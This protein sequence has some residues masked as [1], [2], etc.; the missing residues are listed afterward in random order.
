MGRDKALL[1]VDGVAMA[2]SVASALTDAGAVEVRCIGGDLAGL[3]LLGLDAVP[4]SYEDAGPLA[5]LITGMESTTASMVV[6]APCDL[7]APTG[8]TFRDLVAALEA[9]DAVAVVPIVDGQWRPL[10]VAL[11]RDVL[12]A[13][14][15]A[16][17]QGERAVHRAIER[18]DFEAIDIG[19]IVDADAPEDLPGRR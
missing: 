16:F 8:Q 14:A 4:D 5:G 12:A 11:R 17:A 6:I 2:A 15:D 18:L 9:S 3:R 1:P 19:P 13:L 7:V 10:P